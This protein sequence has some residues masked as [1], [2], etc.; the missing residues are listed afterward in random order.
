[1]H[2][3]EFIKK[4]PVISHR[5]ASQ[6]LAE[7]GHSYDDFVRDCPDAIHDGMEHVYINSKQLFAWLGY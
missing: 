7:H 2:S 4:N 1:M 6:I 3:Q 5:V